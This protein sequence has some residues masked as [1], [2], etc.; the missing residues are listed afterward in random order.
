M[1]QI[2]ALLHARL[3]SRKRGHDEEPA[4][5]SESSKRWAKLSSGEQIA[6]KMNLRTLQYA[7]NLGQYCNEVM[8]EGFRAVEAHYSEEIAILTLQELSALVRGMQKHGDGYRG[9][10]AG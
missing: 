7:M 10:T 1:V 5:K 9:F 4:S 6:K 3:A 2:L 8:T